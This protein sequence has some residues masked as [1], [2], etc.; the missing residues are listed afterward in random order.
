[1]QLEDGSNQLRLN[2]I[3]SDAAAAK[4]QPKQLSRMLIDSGRSKATGP[5][6]N[7]PG[8]EDDDNVPPLM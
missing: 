2:T 8:F 1:M 3:V 6:A 4:A 5:R 7:D